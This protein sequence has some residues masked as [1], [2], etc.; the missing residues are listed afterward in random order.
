[1]NPVPG[2]AA[3]DQICPPSRLPASVESAPPRA[4]L[5][6]AGQSET[7]ADQSQPPG[8][9]AWDWTADETR[10]DDYPEPSVLPRL[11]H[12]PR[13]LPRG[14]VSHLADRGWPVAP[15]ATRC[16][17]AGG[18]HVVNTRRRRRRRGGGRVVADPG[19]RRVTAPVGGG[20]G[21]G[22]E[23][24]VWG[25]VWLVQPA[26]GGRAASGMAPGSTGNAPGRPG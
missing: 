20:S 23:W 15:G 21:R 12:H 7:R 17:L 25:Y 18:L 10:S 5:R 4:V 8:R 24:L 13:R 11:P 26:C 19:S 14:G 22:Y 3:R 2:W 9:P 16:G 1:M 6:E